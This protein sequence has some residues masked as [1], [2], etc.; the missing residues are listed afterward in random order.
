MWELTKSFTFEAAH[1]LERDI[2]REG[3][4]RIHGHSYKAEVTVAGAPDTRTGMILDVG[5]LEHA[6][7]AVGRQL[8]HHF[9]DDITDLG[10]PTMENIARWIWDRLAGEITGMAR[11]TVLRESCGERCTYFGPQKTPALRQP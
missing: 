5:Q 8:D 2:E 6:L 4:K 1:T 3:S 10:P 7:R 9:L 11:V